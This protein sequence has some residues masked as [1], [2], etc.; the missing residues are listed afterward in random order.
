MCEG[1]AEAGKGAM[2]YTPLTNRAM[3]IAYDAHSGQ[4]DKA[5]APYVFHPFHLA[6][7][8]EDETT[9][10]VALLH[11]V[12]EDTDITLGELAREFPPSVID[13]LRLLTHE[14]G[15]DYLEYVR[16]IAQNPVARK[17]KLADLAHNLDSSR[18]AGTGKTG[19]GG[20]AAIGQQARR[21][22]KYLRARDILEEAERENVRREAAMTERS[23]GNY[24]F[25]NHAAC[26]F[27][28]CH[29][30]PAEELNC[31]F[32]FCPLYALGPDCGGNFRYVGEHGDIKDCS[33][34]TVPHR[35]ENYDWLMQQFSRI[36]RL[37]GK[38][39]PG[40]DSD[41]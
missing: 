13:A 7:Q 19:E 3:R 6:E 35:R 36:Q 4:V 34:C 16:A 2:I 31:L 15:V 1:A 8:M 20:P 40:D 10:C 26:E 25:F 28:P 23:K 38:D 22:E 18:F 41:S 27:Y 37:A 29:D 39:E 33:A 5:G 24:Q 32:C 14:D 9:T 11:D 30:M 12:A 21:R 17:V